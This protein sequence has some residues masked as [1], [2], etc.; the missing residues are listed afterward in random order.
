MLTRRTFLTTMAGGAG[1]AL[2][3]SACSWIVRPSAGVLVNDV[4]S[5]LNPTQ[6]DRVLAVD[7]L[8]ALRSA[9]DTARRAGKTVSVA[10]GRHAMGGQQFGADTVLIDTRPMNRVLDLDA[11]RGVVE[12]EAG[13]QW[14]DLIKALVALQA[15]DA[16]SWGIIQ[17]QTGADRL[18]IGGA[19]GA[20]IH[21]R[22]LRLRPMIGDVESFDLVDAE[23]SVLTCSRTEN[24]QLFRLVIGGYGNFG[25]VVRVRLRLMPRTKLE[26]VVEVIDVDDLMPALEKRIA[27][28]FL[29]GDCQFSIDTPSDAFLKTGVFSCYRPLPDDA[30]MPDVERE[31]APDDWRELYYL[32]HADTKRAF[33]RYSSYYLTTSGQRYWSDTHQLSV[34]IENYHREVDRR[35]HAPA[36]GTE[37]IT[38]VYVPRPKL[39]AFLAT[40]RDDFR[41]H[42]VHVIYG[43]IRLIE[44][45]KESFL[46]WASEPWACTVM[47][48]H[49]TH[50]P[51]GLAQAEANFRRIIDRAVEHGGKYF[52][53]Y[54]RWAT[55][56]QIEACY[57]QMA[58]FLTLKQRY[59]P[60]ELFQSDW[61]RYYRA[62][63]KDRLTQ[64][65]TVPAASIAGR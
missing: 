24:A 6:V 49:V 39:A 3:P 47:N 55:R 41:R 16:K 42:S 7:S 63:F 65:R 62:M 5:Q 27:D 54:H 25:V 59:D 20:N 53:T 43:T 22:G 31:L 37:M 12:V 52:L 9:L 29:Y 13:I 30:A 32:A 1:L 35:L 57:P 23:G 11:V 61:Y 34:Y 48:L 51:E 33:E 46:A 64:R 45:D 4:H 38:E 17:K 28:G 15:G 14:P 60:G 10:G 40:L 58:E 2:F 21:G 26:R 8:T 19:L 50:T 18:T 36:Q 44:P 56:E